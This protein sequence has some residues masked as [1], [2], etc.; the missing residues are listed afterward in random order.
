[1]PYNTVNLHTLH[2]KTAKKKKNDDAIGDWRYL[3][4][5]DTDL[6]CTVGILQSGSIC[7]Q[8]LSAG[9]SP[10]ADTS[11]ALHTIRCGLATRRAID[12]ARSLTCHPLSFTFIVPIKQYYWNAKISSI[13]RKMWF[14]LCIQ[15]H[16]HN[17]I[18]HNAVRSH[19]ETGDCCIIYCNEYCDKI[20]L[21][22]LIF[23]LTKSTTF[24][25]I[26]HENKAKT[27]LS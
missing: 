14:S 5:V 2:N 17:W 16:T 4:L 12:S 11:A 8:R 18:T 21:L 1:M 24:V 19:E 15:T 9:A 6:G 25:S 10:V 13:V 26:I 27:P 7:G 22:P 20:K 3:P 23:N